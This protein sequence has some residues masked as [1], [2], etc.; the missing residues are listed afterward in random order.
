MKNK[1]TLKGKSIA[2]MAT[3]G[4][5]E[6]ELTVPKEEL[7]NHGA[8]VHILGEN[9]SIKSWHK[10]QWG[11][12]F[13]TDA[14]I[15]QADPAKYDVLILPGGVLNSDRLRRNNEAVEFVKT[16]SSKNKLI[17]AICH[18]PQLL[19]EADLVESKKMTAHH[20]IKTDMINAGAIYQANRVVQDN[21]F[22]TAMGAGDV[23]DF[24]N[25]IIVYLK[26]E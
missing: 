4:F 10:K 20:A 2:I 19:I 22:I 17:A 16:F 25:R 24:V 21:N 23:P 12:D 9:P 3:D 18:G 13:N 1:E 7:E 26:P 11:R 8:T 14:I 6:V 5:E 15:G